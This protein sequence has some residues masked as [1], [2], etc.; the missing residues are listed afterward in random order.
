MTGKGAARQT[1]NARM[2]SKRG[3]LAHPALAPWS[4]NVTFLW[5]R[6]G[7]RRNKTPDPLHE[8][9][10]LSCMKWHTLRGREA[11]FGAVRA[12]GGRKT[13]FGA[14][15]AGA[16]AAKR[17]SVQSRLHRHR[18]TLGLPAHFVVKTTERAIWPRRF[19]TRTAKTG[20]PGLDRPQSLHR[21]PSGCQEG[22]DCCT[23]TRLAAVRPD[24]TAPGLARLSVSSFTKLIR[25]R[26]TRGIQGHGGDCRNQGRG[27]GRR[28]RPSELTQ[29]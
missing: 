20:N 21:N 10:R 15:L 11:G 16:L 18:R 24:E 3:G 17:V 22:R 7:P 12:P 19:D 14:V 23:E 28:G 5:L 29:S 6:Q 4:R 2:P 9:M 1:T 27:R 26:G 13:R 25:G 8:A